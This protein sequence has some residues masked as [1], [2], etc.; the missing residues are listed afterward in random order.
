M[1]VR[2]PSSA[3]ASWG[4]KIAHGHLRFWPHCDSCRPPSAKRARVVLSA[5]STRLTRLSEPSWRASR[6]C[7]AATLGDRAAWTILVAAF[8]EGGNGPPELRSARVEIR[9]VDLRRNGARRSSR[10]YSV[11]RRSTTDSASSSG[12]APDPAATSVVAAG[13]DAGAAAERTRRSPS[14]GTLPAPGRAVLGPPKLG[15]PAPGQHL[16]TLR[17]ALVAQRISGWPGR[18]IYPRMASDYTPVTV[19]TVVLGR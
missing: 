1:N 4:W 2:D 6:A 10:R 8:N 12:P 7:R 9:A 16:N 11:N 19:T 5:R 13:S 15:C 18:V 17:N 14:S 3:S